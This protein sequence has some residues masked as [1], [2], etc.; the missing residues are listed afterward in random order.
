MANENPAAPT[1]PPANFQGSVTLRRRLEDWVS[2]CRWVSYPLAVFICSR[3]GILAVTGWSSVIDRH[4]HRRLAPT[5]IPAIDHLCLWD[6][7][8]FV[9]IAEQGYRVPQDA[10]FFPLFPLMG[11]F[12]HMVTGIP[13]EWCLLIAANLASLAAL[14][15]IYRLFWALED[16]EIAGTALIYWAAWP[17]S[18]FQAV[19]YPESLMALSS[20]AAI[21]LALRGRHILAGAALG[22]GVLARHLTIIAGPA[23]LVAQL[24]ERGWHPRRLLL[25]SGILGL[26]LPFALPGL[27]FAFLA[28]RFGNPLAWWHAR[29]AGWGEAAWYGVWSFLTGE[30]WDPQIKVYVILSIIPGV[31]AFL[32]LLRKRWWMLAGFA[33]PLMIALWTIGLMGLGRYSGAAWPAFL[34]FAA[35]L[36]KRP[37]FR[38]PVVYLFALLQGMFVYLFAHSYPIN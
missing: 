7:G 19:G 2:R 22:A 28:Q 37:S 20:A 15:I 10:N 1:K 3:I 4:F 14:A 21:Y 36:V 32:L 13:T 18:F 6:C 27:Y 16:E 9:T 23:L 25:N 8:W 26:L 12:L 29:S 17:F 5:R 38:W 33:V 31:G 30:S 34:P 11:R 35:W 24:Q